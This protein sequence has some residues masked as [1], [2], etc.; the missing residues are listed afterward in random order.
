[1]KRI[2]FLG[3]G[4]MGGHM[5]ARLAAAGLE[6][7]AWN[8]SPQKVAALLAQGVQPAASVREALAGSDAAVVM[9]STGAVVDDVLFAGPR[10]AI[11]ALPAGALLAVMSSIPVETAREQARLA[12]AAGIGY[13][14]AP[15][16]GGEPGARDGTLAIFAGGAAEDFARA[17]PLFTPL[18]RATHLGPAGSGQLTKL[19]NQVIVGGTLVAIAEALVLARAG[20]A[21]PVAVR[22]AL[23]GGFGDSKV[24]RVL[25]ARMVEGDFVPGSPAQYQLKDMRTAQQ[26]AGQYGLRLDLLDDLIRRFES[27]VARGDGERDVSVIIREVAAAAGA[28]T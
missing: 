13:L 3:T 5:A 14:D 10:P 8:R 25:G 20:G 12:A 27:L 6:V 22:E 19:A 16:S 1:M 17:A 21:D 2:A 26:L 4:I 7:R 11:A 23:M 9:L 15:V 18:G 24:L 28:A